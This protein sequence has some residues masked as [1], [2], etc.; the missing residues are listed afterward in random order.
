MVE[1]VEMVVW[2]NCKRWLKWLNCRN[3]CVTS[4]VALG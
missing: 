4:V 2:L 3:I 1:M